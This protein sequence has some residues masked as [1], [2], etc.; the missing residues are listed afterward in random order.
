MKPICNEFNDFFLIN[1]GPSVCKKIPMQTSM[2]IDYIKNK[3]TYSLYFEPMHESEIKKPISSLQSNSMDMT[4][5][6]MLY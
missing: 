2:P 3:A 4:W 5:F 6:I 1:V